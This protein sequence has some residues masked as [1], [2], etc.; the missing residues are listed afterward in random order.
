MNARSAEIM[1]EHRNT[2]M[3]EQYRQMTGWMRSRSPQNLLWI[4][5]L[6]DAI[7]DS[8]QHS[9]IRLMEPEDDAEFS[10]LRILID[11]SFIRR[12]E[13][14][15]F[16]REW[17]RN[18]LSK[19]S[20]SALQLPDTWRKRG[21]P[22]VRDYSIYPGVLD[23][24]PL[25]WRRMGF[26]RSRNFVGL[27]IA[28]ICAHAICRYHRGMGAIEAYRQLRPR[29]VGRD[30]AEI[31]KIIVNEQSLHTDDPGNHVGV[32]DPIEFRRRADEI[33]HRPV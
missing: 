24:N 13:H 11:E 18:G 26:F 15:S 32:F 5:G 19:S 28:D 33:R 9:I 1:A 4:I 7:I 14:V 21:H 29:I 10:D 27:Q 2:K 23:V 3:Q 20:R 22:F 12:E 17:L 8:L 30:G 16:W 6:E 25:Y 31:H